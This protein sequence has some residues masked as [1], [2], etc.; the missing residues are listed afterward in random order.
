MLLAV[1]RQRNF[2]WMSTSPADWR[3]RGPDWPPTRYEQKALKAGRRCYY[4]H[5]H[6]G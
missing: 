6:R 5:F 4:F 3:E 2:S 1:D